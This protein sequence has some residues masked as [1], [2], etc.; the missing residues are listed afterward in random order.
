MH[1]ILNISASLVLAGACTP[2]SDPSKTRDTA[3]P[4]GDSGGSGADTSLDSDSDSDSDSAGQETAD[5]RDTPDTGGIDSGP[6]D[7]GSGDTATADTGASDTAIFPSDPMADFALLD[8]NSTSYRY[9][10]PVSPRDYLE[11][12]SGWYFA[13][14]T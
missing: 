3:S 2:P 13:H 10:Q 11:Q 12:V 6:S 14:S 1:P 9:G 4:T 7:S 8:L 5:T